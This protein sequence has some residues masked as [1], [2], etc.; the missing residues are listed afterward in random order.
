MKRQATGPD[1]DMG[2]R[3][4]CQGKVKVLQKAG[5]EIAQI[6]GSSSELPKGIIIYPGD[7]LRSDM[8]VRMLFS[9]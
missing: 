7:G 8:T 5:T 1:I 6:A 9:I 2:G 3:I 4:D